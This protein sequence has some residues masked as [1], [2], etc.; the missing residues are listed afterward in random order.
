MDEL[1]NRISSVLSDPEQMEKITRLARSFMTG[2]G[3]SA[4]PPDSDS[5]SGSDAEMFSR[6]SR[7]M[8]TGGDKEKKER[9]M[10]EAIAPYLSDKRR[11]KMEKAL[12]IAKLVQ[13]ARLAMEEREGNA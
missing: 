6:I 9:A 10:L 4:S 3:D 5:G 1:E 13:I 11:G 7:L 12:Q 2:S 8:C